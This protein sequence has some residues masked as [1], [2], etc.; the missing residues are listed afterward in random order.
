KSAVRA[1]ATAFEKAKDALGKSWAKIK[2]L[3]RKPIKW[4]IDI[5]Y[6]T[7][8]RGL[9]NTAAKVLPIKKL[10]VFKFARGGAVHGPGTATSDSI[11]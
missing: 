10:P 7:G 9:W 1:V 3:T 8:V 6:N 2:S 11:P 4:V 5:V